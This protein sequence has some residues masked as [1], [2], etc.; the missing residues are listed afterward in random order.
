MDQVDNHASKVPSVNTWV[1]VVV[2]IDEAKSGLRDSVEIQGV[3]SRSR[4]HGSGGSIGL[5]GVVASAVGETVRIE[6]VRRV[7]RLDYDVNPPT[8]T[9]SS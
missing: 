1:I 6:C 9:T 8:W 4:G 2:S 3:Y 5:G 7:K